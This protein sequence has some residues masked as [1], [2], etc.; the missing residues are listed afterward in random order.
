VSFAQMTDTGQ[1]LLV[2]AAVRSRDRLLGRVARLLH[3]D[4]IR[5]DTPAGLHMYCTPGGAGQRATQVARMCGG[6]RGS[7][8]AYPA[9]SRGST[10]SA[11]SAP[12]RATSPFRTCT[13]AATV[14]CTVPDGRGCSG[15]IEV[16]EALRIDPPSSHPAACAMFIA[17][18]VP[19]IG[20]NPTHGH[21]INA[22]LRRTG[23]RPVSRTNSTTA[24]AL[25]HSG[26]AAA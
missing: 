22:F 21:D 15:A 10:S 5:V 4:G 26:R 24:D 25:F 8:G 23:T 2:A 17:A 3:Y 20:R 7:S 1:A 12:A 11:P 13:A 14:C 18:C 9:W 19:V 6:R 16:A